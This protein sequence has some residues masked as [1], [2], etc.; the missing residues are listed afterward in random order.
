M[1]YLKYNHCEGIFNNV[2]MLLNKISMI[3]T[4]VGHI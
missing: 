3:I 1:Q 2:L 4:E